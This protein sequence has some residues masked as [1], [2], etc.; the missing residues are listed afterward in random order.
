MDVAEILGPLCQAVT[1]WKHI[2]GLFCGIS[3]AE[4]VL[5]AGSGWQYSVNSFAYRNLQTCRNSNILEI[6]SCWEGSKY[7]FSLLHW[8]SNFEEA[9]VVKDCIERSLCTDLHLSNLKPKQM[10][11][12]N[13]LAEFWSPL[14]QPPCMI[15][16]T[17]GDPL[18][19]ALMFLWV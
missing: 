3:S 10:N 14:T 18:L 19:F 7:G 6:H 4:N 9:N 12:A 13:G 17:V 2:R 16:W 5:P 8:H 15:K 11:F 1:L